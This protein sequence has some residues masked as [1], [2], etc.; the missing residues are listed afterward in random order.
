M[1]LARKIELA[2]EFASRQLHNLAT[3]HPDEFPTFTKDGKWAHQDRS[4][5]RWTEGFVGGQFWLVYNATGDEWF[6]QQAER[7]ALLVEPRKHDREVHDL[8]FVF[9]PTWKRWYDWSGDP[10]HKEVVVEAGRTL[11]GR[12]QDKGGYLCSFQ[13]PESLYIDIMM[14]VG[15][16]FYAAQEDGDQ[17]LWDIAN[18]HC[19]TTRRRLVRGDGSTAHE[20]I[21][22]PE[23]GEF[24]RQSTRQGWREDSTWARGLTWALYG[25]ATAFE[26]TRDPRY[27]ETARLVARY[28][29]E[30]TPLGAVPPNDWEEP[31]PEFRWESSA[32]AIAACGLHMLAQLETEVERSQVYVQAARQTLETLLTAEFLAY[33]TPGWEGILKHGI[34]HLP[35]RAGVDESVIWGDYYF[36]EALSRLGPAM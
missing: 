27:L 16:V 3:R 18:R 28:Y 32:A 10:I 22:D 21:F 9:W 1:A 13:G 7:Y 34:Y 14:N 17:R 30:H 15:L 31:N 23:T 29:L 25:F 35:A 8:G 33:E 11:A 19:L 26:F 36:L 6:R 24:L 5:T 20:G 2:F 12:F 4:W